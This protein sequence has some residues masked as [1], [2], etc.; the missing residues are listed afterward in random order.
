MPP[1]S[2]VS[3]VL[4]SNHSSTRS[5]E[6]YPSSNST[7]PHGAAVLYLP[8][9]SLAHSSKLFIGPNATD[10]LLISS[11]PGALPTGIISATTGPALRQAAILWYKDKN[12]TEKEGTDEDEDDDPEGVRALLCPTL[13]VDKNV[14]D[15]TLPFV[16]HCYSQW[17][18][19]RVFQPVKVAHAM[20]EQVVAQFSSERTRKRTILIANVMDVFARDLSIDATRLFILNHLVLDGHKSGSS[21]MALAS[22][23]PAL[24]RHKAMR[25]LDSILETFSLQIFT[26]PFAACIQSLDYAA[27]VFRCACPEPLGQSVNLANIMLGSDISLQY[28]A[29]LDIIHSVTSGRPTYIQYE[30]PFSLELCEQTYWLQDRYDLQWYL[31]FPVQFILLFAWINSLCEIPGAGNKLELVAWIETSLPQ[32]K[33]AI[34]ESSD[35]SL[36]IGRMVVQECWRF[37]VLIYLYMVLCKADAHDPR[38]RRAQQG[39][40]R[41]VRGV[42]PGRNPDA[43]LSPPMI[44]GGVATISERDRDTLRQRILGIQEFA[45]RG[46]VGNDYVLELEDVWARTRDEGRPA[47]WSDLRIACLKVTGR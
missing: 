29:N 38:V 26:Q 28:F 40:M 12:E 47:L 44:V 24:D 5:N 4:H 43:H 14:K 46:T 39:F 13:A 27:P 11:A 7:S 20:R 9:N 36:R 41:L 10:P 19:A 17:A 2:G 37:A 18:I 3:T 21:F 30:V 25:T 31:G 16:L 6:T 45:E 33:I 34:D 42:K 8:P 22:S 32:I 15:N 1:I 35:S 23:A